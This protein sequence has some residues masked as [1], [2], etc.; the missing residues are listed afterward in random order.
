MTVTRVH[1]D[2]TALTLTVHAEFA[3]D[4]DRVWQLWADPRRLERWWGP[5]MFPATFVA[6]DL[7]PGG[8]FFGSG[9]Q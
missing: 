4:V 3:S 8:G 6:H 7:S 1:K 5:P 2:L 9:G